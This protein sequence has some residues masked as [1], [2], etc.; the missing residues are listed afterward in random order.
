MTRSG[1]AF[2]LRGCAAFAC[3][4]GPAPAQ[5]LFTDVTATHVP[6]DPALHSLDAEFGDFDK[7]G[8]LDVALDVFMGAWGTQAVLLLGTVKQPSSLKGNRR[9][10]GR[11]GRSGALP[12]FPVPSPE[13]RRALAAGRR[14]AWGSAGAL[15]D[16][17]AVA[18]SAAGTP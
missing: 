11:R 8:D 16:G 17:K 2:L 6:Q 12:L 9:G 15:A 18:G 1:K 3:L 4:A 13:G 10:T 14:F 7:D 5:P